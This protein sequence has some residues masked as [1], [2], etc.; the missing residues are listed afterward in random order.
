MINIQ[1]IYHEFLLN[2]GKEHKEKYKEFKGWFSASTAGSCFRKQ[3]YKINDYEEIQPEQR[4]MRLMR[5]GT[6]VHKDLE[7]AII[8]YNK[9]ND[10]QVS[11]YSE[12]RIKLPDLKVVG[13]LDLAVDNEGKLYVYDIKTAHSFK[14]KK[15]FGRNVD[16]NP[17]TNYQLQLGTYALG[18][19]KHLEREEDSDN[20]ELGLIWYKKDD[21][22]MKTQII[23]S[24]W[25]K[26]AFY[27][28][29]ELNETLEEQ[30]KPEIGSYN[31]PVYKWE[32]RYCPFHKIECQGV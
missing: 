31:T 17:S 16:P 32:C 22:M 5:L 10:E 3:W 13:H 9:S 30:G 23:S 19:L 15:L 27:Y 8:E 11:V 21:S 1:N 20:V 25:I 4:P 18:M 28:W 12:Y 7:E 26:N 24:E 2:K 14:W 6:L 29:V